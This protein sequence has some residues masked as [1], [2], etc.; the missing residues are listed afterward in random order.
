MN[1]K[2]QSHV[3]P[4][5]GYEAP[6]P[7]HLMDAVEFLTATFKMPSITF[8]LQDNKCID[9]IFSTDAGDIEADCIV[10]NNIHNIEDIYIVNDT[11]KAHNLS[12]SQWVL[13][14][15][16]IR[17]IAGYHI[18]LSLIN[19]S[20][21]ICL[22][23]TQPH[24]FS[25]S[26][27]STFIAFIELLTKTLYKILKRNEAEYINQTYQELSDEASHDLRMRINEIVFQSIINGKTDEDM[28]KDLL[29]GMR[30]DI[31]AEAGQA[32]ILGESGHLE[33]NS[34][35]STSDETIW[36][37]FHESS[38]TPE[39]DDYGNVSYF[40]QN[41]ALPVVTCDFGNFISQQRLAIINKIWDY[42]LFLIPIMCAGRIVGIFEFVLINRR[43]PNFNYLISV[44]KVMQQ[45]VTPVLINHYETRGYKITYN[46]LLE[47][48]QRLRTIV[49]STPIIII[50][51]DLTG[52]IIFCE[53]NGLS[54]INLEPV[55]LIDKCIFDC[56]EF[57]QIFQPIRQA[58]D[59][60]AATT[61][62]TINTISFKT[63]CLPVFDADGLISNAICIASDVTDLVLFE[64]ELEIRNVELQA[65][66]HE[67]REHQKQLEMTSED[68]RIAKQIADNTSY[69]FQEL[70]QESPTA[71]CSYDNLGSVQEWNRSFEALTGRNPTDILQRPLGDFFFHNDKKQYKTDN[72]SQLLK[73][74]SVQK[75][76]RKIIRSDGSIRY[77]IHIAFPLRDIHGNIIGGI[78]SFSD[79][80]EMEDMRQE[81][82]AQKAFLTTVINSLP[83][84][85]FVLDKNMNCTLANKT[86]AVNHLRKVEEVVGKNISEL[87]DAKQAASI[88]QEYQQILKHKKSV[89][90]KDLKVI[91]KDGTVFWADSF[92]YPFTS[93]DNKIDYLLIVATDIT[94]RIKAEEDLRIAKETAE[95]AN[96]AKS[97]FLANMSHELRTPLNAII[98]FS[99]VLYD[100]LFG[101]LNPKQ[102]KY[103]GNILNSGKHLLQLIND[104]LDLAKIE[105]GK[106]ELDYSLFEP[107]TAIEDIL[108]IIKALASKK[109]IKV[110]RQLPFPLPQI[111]AD[112]AKFKQILFNLL[113]NAV[114]FTPNGGSVTIYA[115]ESGKDI[116][117]SI[118]DTG[119]GIDEIDI[120]RIFKEFVQLDSSYARNQEGTGL[121]L[122]LTLKLV[123][124]HGGEIHVKSAGAGK[125]TT[126]YVS[127]P[128]GKSED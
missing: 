90:I 28:L 79:V 82:L 3:A 116:I 78:S 65:Q 32:W 100:S 37:S 120:P 34:I 19:V 104:I 26:E 5:P 16:Y 46:A 92:R 83:S 23:D 97:R 85:V 71:C 4:Q 75:T 76:K 9:R 45:V 67:L 86:F 72:I 56:Q 27:K 73:G 25:D 128:I 115:E 22:I 49:T 109:D 111:Y 96:I 57:Q 21:I 38:I 43:A 88:M 84:E 30:L 112:K 123:K 118:Q 121:G 6:L 20:I 39:T 107:E 63:K 59:G 36:H 1:E 105:A 7:A 94:H 125:G 12:N 91:R 80:T 124:M 15:S 95:S 47:S 35:W 66:Q 102:I 8:V 99:E 52:K 11:T 53:G 48:E 106:L 18:K 113:S 117:I 24:I 40:L 44:G 87:M 103:V 81:L 50:S 68:L 108:D 42:L 62:V 93:I 119:I 17:F 51:V 114:K 33:C 101:E 110:Y 54:A 13:H 61:L 122:S 55:E 10:L 60:I 89:H 29:D 77:V 98:G 2:L 31:H 127:L 64:K 14:P 126:F 74:V 70:F 69:R 58:I 41:D